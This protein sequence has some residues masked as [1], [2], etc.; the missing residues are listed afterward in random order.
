MKTIELTQGKAA[1]VDDCDYVYLSQ[2]KWRYS[3]KG[4]AVRTIPTPEKNRRQGVEYMHRVILALPDELEVDHV[5]H[6]KLNNQRA[7]LRGVTHRENIFNQT[8]RKN[9]TSKHKG[10]SWD[11]AQHKWV[12]QIQ[13]NKKKRALGVFDNENEAVEAYNTAAIKLFGEFAC[14]NEIEY[15]NA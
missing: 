7:N 14:L 11:T 2:W 13:F 5:E 10:V 15:E 8:P 4:Y 12:T 1:L 9:T 3:T 6:S